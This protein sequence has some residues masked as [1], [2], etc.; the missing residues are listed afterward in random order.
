MTVIEYGGSFVFSERAFELRVAGD[1]A[2]VAARVDERLE[3][4]GARGALELDA[5]VVRGGR[6]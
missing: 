1:E 6:R 4:A 3:R 2:L 5:R